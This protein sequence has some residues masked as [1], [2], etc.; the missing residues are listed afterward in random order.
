MDLIKK[1]E[2]LMVFMYE[3]YE[4]DDVFKQYGDY[5]WPLIEE[6]GIEFGDAGAQLAVMDILRKHGFIEVVRPTRSAKIVSYSRV[7]PSLKGMEFV[8]D[9]RK[10]ILR[11]EWPKVISAITEGFIKGLKG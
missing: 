2:K 8:R 11:R 5:P 4:E 9:K 3:K 1:L 6:S 7:R 10:S